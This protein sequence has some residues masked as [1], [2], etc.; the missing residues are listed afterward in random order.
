MHVTSLPKSPPIRSFRLIKILLIQPSGRHRIDVGRIP[1]QSFALIR[2][3]CEEKEK[4][5]NPPQAIQ[6]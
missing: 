6:D 2:L 4:N 1:P 5:K 3:K